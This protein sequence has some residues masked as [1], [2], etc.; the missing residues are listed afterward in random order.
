MTA[1]SV[2]REE[3]QLLHNKPSLQNRER[4]ISCT[5]EYQAAI[6]RKETS[7]R[8][9]DIDETSYKHCCTNTMGESKSADMIAQA[10]QR[11]G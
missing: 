3:R 11:S 2:S 1:P 6:T 10:C 8:E 5:C 9:E 4:E 7:S